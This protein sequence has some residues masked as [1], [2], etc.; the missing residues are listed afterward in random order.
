MA[1]Q[2]FWLFRVPGKFDPSVLDGV[3]F[4]TNQSQIKLDDDDN[5][6]IA[7][8]VELSSGGYPV[9][10]LADEDDDLS[11]GPLFEK[12]FQVV[13]KTL[14]PLPT[15]GPNVNRKPTITQLDSKSLSF[16]L[17]PF[18]A[19][20]ESQ[21]APP[22]QTTKAKAKKVAG[23]TPKKNKE[24]TVYTASKAETD[25]PAKKVKKVKKEKRKTKEKF[26]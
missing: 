8:T 25:K 6:L 10:L 26:T 5:S 20:K 13:K 9:A 11:A 18:G 16:R 21:E 3:T 12:S 14:I 4:D 17:K 7:D 2:Q 23:K 1:K 15:L 24:E 22:D 19:I